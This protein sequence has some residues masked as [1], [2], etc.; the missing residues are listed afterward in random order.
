MKSIRV[1]TAPIAAAVI[2]VAASLSCTSEETPPPGYDGPDV[3]QGFVF[4]DVNENGIRDDGEPGIEGVRVSDQRSV[5]ATDEMGRWVLPEHDEAIYFVVK[6]RGYRTAL[7]ENNLPL[8]YHVHKNTEALPFAEPTVQPTGPLPESVDFGLIPQTEPDQFKAL[9]LGDPQPRS[10]EEVDFLAHDVLEE[11]VGTDA[12]FAVVLGDISFDNKATY[13]PYIQAAGRV[14]VPFYNV[15]GNHDANY[16]GM[17]THQHYD[18][19]RT[20]F[21]PRYYSFDYGPVHFMIL[22]DVAWPEQGPSYV[23]GLGREQLAWIEAD[24]AHVPLEKLVVLAMH[25]PLTPAEQ[26]PDFG[27]LY[28][29]LQNHPHTLSFSAHSHTISQGFITEE[30]GWKRPNPHHHIV[31]GATCGAWWE[32]PRDETDIPHATGSDGAPNGYFVAS[33]DG[34]EYSTRFKAARRPADYQMQ[35]QAPEEVAVAALAET[36]VILNY[37]GGTERAVVEMSV[38]QSGD[39]VPMEFSPQRDPLF[40]RLSENAGGR[41]A[42]VS[43]HIWEGR[44]PAGLPVGGH[45]IRIRTV[46]MY[47]QEFSASRIVRVKEAVE[48]PDPPEEGSNIS[49]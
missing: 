28:E 40:V 2:L 13:L 27:R 8:F 6:P 15:T 1:A 29:L 36:P 11:M 42:S 17:D 9:F 10:V 5:T 34:T 3:A 22:A 23:T 32:G 4:H 39:W 14:G 7:S 43:R 30:F 49:G 44:L 46:D 24:L 45:L 33:F 48:T 19:W 38:G 41:R 16:E 37:F 26:N 12:G 20:I 18:T 35:I 31:S 21:G 25:I 47:G